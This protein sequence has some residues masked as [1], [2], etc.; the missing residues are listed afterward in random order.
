MAQSK[1]RMYGA[2]WCPD[3]R[4]A[5]QFLGEQRVTYEWVDVDKDPDGLRYV[6]EV[7]EGKQ[8]IPTIVFQDGSILVEP[9]NTELAV[10]LGISTEPRSD[11]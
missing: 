3:C 7:N 5:K 10:K 6:Q 8:I 9:T 4:Q 11:F 2:P 1:I